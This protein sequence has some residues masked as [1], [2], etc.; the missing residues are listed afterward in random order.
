MQAHFDHQVPV[1]HE[2]HACQ[3]QQEEEVEDAQF[4]LAVGVQLLQEPLLV[5]LE[6]LLLDLLE[7]FLVV[8]GGLPAGGGDVAGSPGSLLDGF[9][10]L[11]ELLLQVLNLFLNGVL[12]FL[13]QFLLCLLLQGLL[14]GEVE[15]LVF[16]GERFLSLL[17]H[18][19]DVLLHDLGDGSAL[20]AGK[21]N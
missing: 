13:P 3:C 12:R 15:D 21:V 17:V 4:G 10:R 16:G 5:H 20:G 1:V 2:A 14:R 6:A 9:L 18:G 19:R 8:L 11:L 7:L